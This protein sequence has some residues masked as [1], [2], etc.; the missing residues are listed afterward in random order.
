MN[1]TNIYLLKCRTTQKTLI[2]ESIDEAYITLKRIEIFYKNY[3]KN[4]FYK[5]QAFIILQNKNY[6]IKKIN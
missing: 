4:R 2:I 5:E 6:Y 1:Y 3:L